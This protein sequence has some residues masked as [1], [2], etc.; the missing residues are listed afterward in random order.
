MVA[1]WKNHTPAGKATDALIDFTD[2]YSTFAEAAGIELGADDPVDGV[3]FYPSLVGKPGREREW[4]LCHYQPYWNKEPGQFVR[5]QKFKLYR[6]GRC[7]NL[8]VGDLEEQRNLGDA[9]PSAAEIEIEKLKA[10]IDQ[11]PPAPT[12]KGTRKTIDRPTWPTW[13]QLPAQK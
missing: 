9:I 11:L 2:F 4:A 13:K 6:D 1:M 7:Y 10:L 3:S 8:S 5:D 12:G